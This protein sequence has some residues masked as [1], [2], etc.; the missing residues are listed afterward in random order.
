[1]IPEGKYDAEALATIDLRTWQMEG[2]RL[3]RS[4]APASQ[5]GTPSDLQ[6]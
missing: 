1:M 3:R 5:Q 4:R 6:S 2:N